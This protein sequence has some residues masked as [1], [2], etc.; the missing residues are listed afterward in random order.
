MRWLRLVLLAVALAGAGAAGAAA[1]G[2]FHTK[3]LAEAR[4]IAAVEAGVL[5]RSDQP[6]GEHL[7]TLR[8]PY[9]IRTV[10]NLRENEPNSSWQKAEEEFCRAN[11]IRY[12]QMA[13]SQ[14]GFTPAELAQFL[15]IVQDPASQ[16][17]LLHCEHGRNRTGFAS[18]VYRIVVQHWTYE[19]AVDEAVDR[20]FHPHSDRGYDHFLRALGSGDD[21]FAPEPAAATDSPGT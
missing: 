13:I 10:V 12:V 19:A 18:A 2:F 17:V 1:L 14:D 15:Q 4:T 11:G 9:H 3:G 21:P 16:P 7:K 8:D 6:E 20:G 5:Y